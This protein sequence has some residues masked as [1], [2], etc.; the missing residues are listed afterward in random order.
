MF[1]AVVIFVVGVVFFARLEEVLRGSGAENRW[2]GPEPCHPFPGVGHVRQNTV[3]APGLIHFAEPA[4]ITMLVRGKPRSGVLTQI[5]IRASVSSVAG[6]FVRRDV[7]ATT[8]PDDNYPVMAALADLVP[9][10]RHP[11]IVEEHKTGLPPITALAGGI[12]IS[13]DV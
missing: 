7:G 6:Q 8:L 2:V 10:D 9:C 4:C 12:R 1:V 13:Q 11:G 5:D 3:F